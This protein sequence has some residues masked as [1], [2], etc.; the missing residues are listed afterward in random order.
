MTSATEPRTGSAGEAADGAV[1]VTLRT[2]DGQRL[3]FPCAPGQSVLEAAAEWGAAL[4]A[5]CRQGTCGSC[6][7]TVVSG[8]YDLGAHSTQA[9]PPGERANGGVLLCR[10][11]PREA[12]AAELPYDDSRIVYG[13]IPV[14]EGTLTALEHVARGT[15]RLELVLEPDEEEGGGFQ[16]D[17]GQFVEVEVPGSGGARRVYSLANTGNWDG[18]LE[19]Y[20][21]LLP[22]GLFSSYL[23]ERA[24]VGDRLTVHGPQ[25]AFGLRE[26]GLRPRWFVAG[27]TG[28]APLLS[29][30][31]QM[32][33]W[34]EPQRARFYFGVNEEDDVFGE[35]P[36]QEIAAGLPG[37]TH[38][39]CVRRPGTRWQ[40]AIGTPAERLGD[41]LRTLDGT[42]SPDIY[43]CG[44]PPLIEAVTNVATTQGI[45]Q[46]RVFRE[47]FLPT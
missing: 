39:I 27:G 14:R 43:V 33:E 10:T 37:F 40:G 11:F 2:F 24:R 8:A 5:A 29:M 30:A 7:A 1:P 9:L 47:L 22:D 31:R 34:Q 18:V 44:P 41:A 19:L 38:E 3:E 46:D 32:A 4:P 17:A 21:K 25:G 36:L 23:R 15:V 13:S 35:A 42:E 6:R 26:T 12:L 16:F 20:V 45:S 28:L